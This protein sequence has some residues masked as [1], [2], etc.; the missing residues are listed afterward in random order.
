MSTLRRSALTAFLVAALV[1][2]ID[3]E[4]SGAAK[5]PQENRRQYRLAA[6]LQPELVVRRPVGTGSGTTGAISLRVDRNAMG[7]GHVIKPLMVFEGLTGP[8]T[9]VHI[10]TGR[11]GRSGPVLYTLCAPNPGAAA[12]PR[13]NHGPGGFVWRAGP[14]F[15]PAVVGPTYVDVHTK[16]NPGGE[17]RGQVS[18]TPLER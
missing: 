10:H 7:G 18:A 16:R 13:C 17:L 9:A 12:T 6:V 15:D 8:P 14:F 5:A 2:A 4:R 11:A 3:H 1:V